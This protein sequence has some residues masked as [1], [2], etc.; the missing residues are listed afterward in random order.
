MTRKTA[1]EVEIEIDGK[2]YAGNW[3]RVGD[4]IEVQYLGTRPETTALG[5]WAPEEAA[6]IL[7]NEMVQ[8]SLAKRKR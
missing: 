1:G 7:L 3:K 4:S 5:K 2:L 8:K 6:K